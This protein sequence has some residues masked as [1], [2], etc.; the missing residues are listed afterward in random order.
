MIY[1]LIDVESEGE[2]VR[3][4]PIGQVSEHLMDSLLE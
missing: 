4:F 3:N 2:K 1:K